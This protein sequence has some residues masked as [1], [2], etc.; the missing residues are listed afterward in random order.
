MEIVT[1]KKKQTLDSI[2]FGICFNFEINNIDL[3][4]TSMLNSNQLSFKK[5]LNDGRFFKIDY[6]CFYYNQNHRQILF[7]ETVFS[8]NEN[9]GQFFAMLFCHSMSI[10][11]NKSSF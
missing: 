4:L 11:W 10:I 8:L 2:S 6:Y 5:Y 7:F 3:F 9:S 1:L